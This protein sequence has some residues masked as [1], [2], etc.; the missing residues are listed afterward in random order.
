[1]K[2]LSLIY[3]FI[4]F[5]VILIL[6]SCSSNLFTG[7][8]FKLD[9][10]KVE[11][12]IPEHLPITNIQISPRQTIKPQATSNK[13]HLD[14]KPLSIKLNSLQ[15]D[16]NSKQ[17]SIHKQNLEQES[18]TQSNLIVK[19]NSNVFEDDTIQ[20]GFDWISLVSLIS[21]IAG[22]FLFIYLLFTGYSGLWMVSLFFSIILGI[23]GIFRTR[24]KKRKGKGFAIAG[25]TLGVLQ[26]LYLI[27]IIILWSGLGAD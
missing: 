2:G 9:L 11:K 10:V 25:L 19:S 12:S 3:S 22:T 8:R 1:M 6:S 4:F 27:T 17:K 20:N 21:G 18:Q 23:F 15:P 7:R 16:V 13:D 5:S 26:I 14:I 24:H